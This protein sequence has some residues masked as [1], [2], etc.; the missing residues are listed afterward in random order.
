VAAAAARPGRR[1][2]LLRL[3]TWILEDLE[4]RPAYRSPELYRNLGIAWHLS[5]DFAPDA[6]AKARA[7][8]E[9][10]L[11]APEDGDPNLDRIR[12]LYAALAAEK[13]E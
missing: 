4:R 9:K 3:A 13:G 12:E 7:A 8:W 10:Y 2:E 5:R 6:A 11:A 1:E